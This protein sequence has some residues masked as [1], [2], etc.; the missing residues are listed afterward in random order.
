MI[1]EGAAKFKIDMMIKTSRDLLDGM[2]PKRH[3][4]QQGGIHA[5]VGKCWTTFAKVHKF[6]F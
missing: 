3:R 6:S 4:G 2:E 1:E 5:E